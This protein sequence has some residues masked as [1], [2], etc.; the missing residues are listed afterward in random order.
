MFGKGYTLN[1]V[2]NL[3][4]FLNFFA[5]KYVKLFNILINI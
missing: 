4:V 3:A 5:I 1:K 2:S